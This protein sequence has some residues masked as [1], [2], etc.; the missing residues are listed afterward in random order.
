MIDELAI[1][2]ASAI[3]VAIIFAD[4]ASDFAGPRQD[5]LSTAII[6]QSIGSFNVFS[7]CFHFGLGLC[8]SHNPIPSSSV[9]H[10]ICNF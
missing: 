8:Y 1:P 2:F 4:V 10:V 9:F 7:L 3:V 5:L 6:H